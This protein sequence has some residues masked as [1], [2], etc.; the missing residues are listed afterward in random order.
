[1]LK[2]NFNFKNFLSNSKE[3]SIFLKK[4]R[5]RKESLDILLLKVSYPK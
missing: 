4:I 1:M 2:T 5:I 3:V